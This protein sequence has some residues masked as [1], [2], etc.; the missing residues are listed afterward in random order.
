MKVKHI[1]N[2]NMVSRI[3][4]EIKEILD[5]IDDGE[6]DATICDSYEDYSISMLDFI[7][8]KNKIWFSKLFR[9]ISGEIDNGADEM[10]LRKELKA[11]NLHKKL[12]NHMVDEIFDDKNTGKCIVNKKE[13]QYKLMS[14][15]PHQANIFPIIKKH[16]RNNKNGRL[17]LPC[18]TG[19]TFIGYWTAIKILECNR[20]FVIVPSLYLLSETYAQWMNEIQSIRPRFN[21]TLIGSDIEDKNACK[22]KPTTDLEVIKQ[23][24]EKYDRHIVITTYQSSE[25]LLNACKELDFVFD[26]GIFDEAHRTTGES[27]KM[28]TYLLSD[29]YNISDKRMFMTATEK[30]YNYSK[31]KLPKDE[32]EEQVLSMDNEKIY[33]KVIYKYS[34][35][36]AID[37][38]QLVD[39][40]IVAPFMS[41]DMYD[42]L[43]EENEIVR[44]LSKKKNDKGKKKYEMKLIL[45]CVVIKQA[46]DSCGFTH[47]LIFSN[48]NKKAKEIYEI[49]SELNPDDDM[50][51][52][53]LSGDDNMTLRRSEVAKFEKAEKGIISS[54]RIFG[55][56]VNIKIC[57][58]VCFADSKES[59]VDIVQY[60]GR[61]LRKYAMKPNKIGYVLIPFLIENDYEDNFLTNDNDS[62]LKLRKILKTLGDTDDVISEKFVLMNCGEQ[63]ITVSDEDKDEYEHCSVADESNE[64]FNLNKFAQHIV[65]KIFDRSGDRDTRIRNM[66]IRENERRWG[67][68]HLIDTK[69]KYFEFLRK[70]GIEDEYPKIHNWTKYCLGTKLFNE[71]QKKYYYDKN[72][73]VNACRRLAIQ[74]NGEYRKKYQKDVKL[75]SPEYINDGFYYDLDQKFNLQILLN[76]NADTDDV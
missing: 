58:A 19:K 2:H 12:I 70:H 61:C 44:V 57:D 76:N 63:N 13:I 67:K 5:A 69:L 17:Y 52:K 42:G 3:K 46:M 21:F 55:E 53:C 7:K 25:L 75:P 18:G 37:D 31:T 30:V 47:L 62:Y 68:G 9:M 71:M 48:N 38:G 15:L 39:Y 34:T 24:L 36:Q 32:I 65:S 59:S 27:D 28:F 73:F 49:L 10:S 26:F 60:V 54:A 51:L 41:T 43:I 20:V 33:G 22:H 50:Y 23:N 64:T 29:K 16:Y 74:S 8:T 40:K 56:G 11:G 1:K 72:Q 6:T 45:L 14:P 66:V 4:K 35:R